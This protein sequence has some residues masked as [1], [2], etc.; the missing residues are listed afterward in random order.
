MHSEA[1]VFSF[2]ERPFV[3]TI[4]K[5]FLSF[6]NALTFSHMP[7]TKVGKTLPSSCGTTIL[8]YLFEAVTII[9]PVRVKKSVFDEIR[10]AMGKLKFT[11][12]VVLPWV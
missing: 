10:D 3:W 4:L 7:C 1:L 5:H 12:C 6:L 8:K 2:T 11:D 9:S